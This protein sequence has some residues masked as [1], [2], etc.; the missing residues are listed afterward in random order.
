[1]RAAAGGSLSVTDTIKNTGSA[2]AGASVTAFYFSTDLTLDGTDPHP[3][4]TRAVP[5]LL[6]NDVNTGTTTL[7]VPDLAP[8][9]WF[10]LANADDTNAVPETLE[11]N[12]LKF[13][14]VLVGP[15]L[16]FLTVNA[17]TTA[18]AGATIAVS[19]TVRNIGAAPVAAST[20]RFYLSTNT[21]VDAGDV[22]LD[23][24]QA[25]PALAPD[26]TA[27]ATTQVPL[28]QGMSGSFYLLMMADGVQAIVEAS[29][30]NNVAAR[31]LQLNR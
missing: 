2:T 10:L 7:T 18:L 4:Q 3:P 13:A 20:V 22:L 21:S 12:N 31:T 19:T 23:A 25:V 15:D 26:G 28:P 6:A 5:A 11:N 30:S 24:T 27:S 17:P 14:T 16:S 29:E 8:G 1:L 9:T